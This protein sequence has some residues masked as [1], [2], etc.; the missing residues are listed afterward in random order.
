M[1]ALSL[2][3]VEHNLSHVGLLLHPLQ[4]VLGQCGD[5][6]GSCC[7]L[8]C[9][10]VVLWAYVDLCCTNIKP[11]WLMLDRCWVVWE[12]VGATL[13]PYFIFNIGLILSQF[14]ANIGLMLSHFGSVLACISDLGISVS[15]S[16]GFGSTQGVCKKIQYTPQRKQTLFGCLAHVL[17]PCLIMFARY[18]SDVA[19]AFEW[20]GWSLAGGCLGGGGIACCEL[21]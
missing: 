12:Y 14:W 2:A 21:A 11:S 3:H 16:F 5:H 8:H 10:D 20:Y 13:G 17:M 6:V 4:P 1:L 7:W 9:N 15:W 19:V 18:F